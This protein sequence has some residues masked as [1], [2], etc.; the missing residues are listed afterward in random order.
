MKLLLSVLLLC[1][2]AKLV[3]LATVARFEFVEEWNLWKQEHEKEYETEEVRAAWRL[4]SFLYNSAV[5]GTI[6]TTSQAYI[7]ICTYKHAHR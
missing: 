1:L 7:Y 3:R 5:L 4:S 6:T 2:A